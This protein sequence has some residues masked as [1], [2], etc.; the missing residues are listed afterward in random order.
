MR[1][2]PYSVA[3][4]TLALV[5]FGIS[6]TLPP[7]AEGGNERAQRSAKIVRASSADDSSTRASTTRASTSRASTTRA[8]TTRAVAPGRKRPSPS[9]KVG[10]PADKL[11]ADQQH[12]E[13]VRLAKSGRH[14]AAVE[15]F[16]EAIAAYPLNPTYYNNLAVLLRQK[17][18]LL[19]AER[20][21]RKAI[22]LDPQFAGAWRNLGVT[23]AQRKKYPQA[24]Q[25]LIRARKLNRSIASRKQIDQLIAKIDAAFMRRRTETN[26]IIAPAT[27]SKHLHR[28]LQ[29][30]TKPK[31]AAA[32]K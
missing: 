18:R 25:A 11:K 9:A 17:G 10:D 27:D 13:A 31:D 32:S 23:L 16:R 26:N 29:L 28:S 19:D 15:K 6:F 7:P 12:D 4:L 2:A 24:K 5:V 14:T 20:Y 30:P 21:F 22:E 8:S 1:L 3:S